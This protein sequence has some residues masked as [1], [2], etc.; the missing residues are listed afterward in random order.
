MHLDKHWTDQIQLIL[1]QM[2]IETIQFEGC[3]CDIPAAVLMPLFYKDDEW[4]ILFIRRSEKMV[5]HRG[6]VAFPGGRAEPEDDSPEDTALR[7]TREEIGIQPN[8]VQILGRMQPVCTISNYKVTP[9]VGEIPYP[10][11]L[12]LCSDEVSHV[13]SVPVAWL[14]EENH[15]QIRKMTFG[16]GRSAEVIY[17]SEYQ[18]EIVWGITGYITLRFLQI[19]SLV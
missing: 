7:E 13:F 16:N 11:T 15:H 2:P 18:R 17:F 19:M 1:P 5:S 8:L 10:H 12:Q 3:G 14:A 4:H 6:Q 9:V